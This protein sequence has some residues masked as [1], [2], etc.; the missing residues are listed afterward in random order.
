VDA[1]IGE[2]MLELGMLTH[3]IRDTVK[4]R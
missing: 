3:Q 1:R 2:G 4:H